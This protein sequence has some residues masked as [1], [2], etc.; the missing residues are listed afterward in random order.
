M[1]QNHVKC[2]SILIC[3]LLSITIMFQI[4]VRI[5]TTD[6]LHYLQITQN[7]FR[8][9][10]ALE[11]QRQHSSRSSYSEFH[12]SAHLKT[13]SVTNIFRYCDLHHQCHY[14][15]S[16][17]SYNNSS[18]T[19]VKCTFRMVQS[20]INKYIQFKDQSLWNCWRFQ[21]KKTGS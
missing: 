10:T 4:Y 13:A 20:V 6:W 21:I 17:C 16:R 14:K 1:D 19:Q 5:P 15:H 11:E 2:H 18:N 7:L 12:C 3:N 9:G 8:F